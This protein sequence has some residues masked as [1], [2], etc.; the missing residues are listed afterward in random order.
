[1]K[2][3]TYKELI[4]VIKGE[5][6]DEVNRVLWERKYIQA[7]KSQN[8]KLLEEL[9]ACQPGTPCSSRKRRILHLA[10][11]MLR[12]KALEQI[13]PKRYKDRGC[14]YVDRQVSYLLRTWRE[15][16][17][18]DIA[19]YEARKSAKEAINETK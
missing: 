5:I 11:G 14:E 13:E 12:G 17:A 10:Y 19:A 6:K 1:M 9:L 4:S 3:T 15:S 16:I 7:S 2:T 18:E 8:E